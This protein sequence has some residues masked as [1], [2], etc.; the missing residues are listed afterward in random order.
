MVVSVSIK[1]VIQVSPLVQESTGLYEGHTQLWAGVLLQPAHCVGVGIS[2]ILQV[3]KPGQ[4]KAK[5][6]ASDPK[7]T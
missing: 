3:K 5:C 7:A 1:M 6:L 2:L 4:G